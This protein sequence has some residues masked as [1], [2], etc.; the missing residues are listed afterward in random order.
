LATTAG[1]ALW[2]NWTLLKKQGSGV[3]DIP[4]WFMR[5]IRLAKFGLHRLQNHLPDHVHPAHMLMLG[6]LAA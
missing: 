4:S 5:F 6:S 1:S 3:A 2:R